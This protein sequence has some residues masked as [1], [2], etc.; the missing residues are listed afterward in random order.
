MKS[1]ITKRN[2]PTRKTLNKKTSG[3]SCLINFQN[4]FQRK[5]VSK[6]LLCIS[7]SRRLFFINLLI[8]G[9][10][11]FVVRATCLPP[12]FFGFV[13]VFLLWDRPAWAFSPVPNFT[14]QK[15]TFRAPLWARGAVVPSLRGESGE[16]YLLDAA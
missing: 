1:S 5:N 10:R 11:N 15:P 14:R 9:I 13:I 8:L 4:T 3:D 12:I 16:G 7:K 6:S 2:A